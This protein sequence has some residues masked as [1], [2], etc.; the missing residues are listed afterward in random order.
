MK[1]KNIRK[2]IFLYL[3][4][5]T[6][7]LFGCNNKE[8][9]SL[10]NKIFYK[11]INDLNIKNENA[12]FLRNLQGSYLAGRIS[13]DTILFIYYNNEIILSYNVKTK[14]KQVIY[15]MVSLDSNLKKIELNTGLIK[16]NY[17]NNIKLSNIKNLKKYFHLTRH[18]N[19]ENIYS[20]DWNDLNKNNITN[21][22]SISSIY[23]IDSLNGYYAFQDY[24][25]E[26]L[27]TIYYLYKINDKINIKKHY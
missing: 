25:K 12:L 22:Y 15:N 20:L 11:T 5:I 2:N 18:N 9:E 16:E 3:L 19:L 1:K 27:K 7:I 4:F 26:R 8:N 6:I 10:E 21:I 24:S 17:I 23:Q 13:K 14:N